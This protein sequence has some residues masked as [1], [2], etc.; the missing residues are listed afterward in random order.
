MLLVFNPFQDF[1]KDTFDYPAAWLFSQKLQI[2]NRLF[3]NRKSVEV[4]G[5]TA[6]ICSPL[7]TRE[8]LRMDEHEQRC[9]NNLLPCRRA[10]VMTHGMKSRFGSADLTIIMG[11]CKT[12]PLLSEQ[13]ECLQ[14]DRVVAGNAL[15]P[16]LISPNACD[17]IIAQNANGIIMRSDSS[18]FSLT[19]FSRWVA[20]SSVY[21]KDFLRL[22]PGLKAPQWHIV[23]NMPKRKTF[24][25]SDAA[26]VNIY[27]AP[28]L[29]DFFPNLFA[30]TY[31]GTVIKSR[32]K[33]ETGGSLQR[34]ARSSYFTIT[35][36]DPVVKV[37]SNDQ[38]KLYNS[39]FFLFCWVGCHSARKGIKK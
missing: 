2:K 31:E 3:K 19:L 6:A 7:P 27:F 13:A 9:I 23:N 20:H 37:W 21:Y 8:P 34:Q 1:V 22:S 12:P 10:T 33:H 35:E 16:T 11:D 17:T 25:S 5:V 36:T 18:R 30:W 4:P 28:A 15:P 14:Y 26:T 29:L 24:L 39:F 32:M 38:K